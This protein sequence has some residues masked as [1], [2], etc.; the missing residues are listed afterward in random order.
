M[1]SM[2]NQWLKLSKREQAMTL[3]GAI[4]GL[5]LIVYLAA[6]KPLENTHAKLTNQ[7]NEQQRDLTWLQQKR[8]EV[9]QLLPLQVAQKKNDTALFTLIEQSLQDNEL[10]LITSQITANNDDNI[11]IQFASIHFDVFIQWINEIEKQYTI[12][13]TQASVE[14]IVENPGQ[15]QVN[16]N[17]ARA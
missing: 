5:F 6:W 1:N 2:K 14:R 15:I 9:S 8:I 10:Y 17:L 11:S 3:I 13:V 16:V 12:T 7:I 4:V